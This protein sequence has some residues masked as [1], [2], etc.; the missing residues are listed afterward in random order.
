[1]VAQIDEQHAAMI[2]NAMAPARQPN[3]L[4][5]IA[6]AERAAGMG[7][8]TMHGV[9]KDQCWKVESGAQSLPKARG[10]C[11]RGRKGRQPNA[12]T[13]L[14]SKNRLAMPILGA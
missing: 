8:V 10:G 4:A 1:M 2:A 9:L 13:D 14:G 7:P 6:L 3:R 5:N 11:T 12:G